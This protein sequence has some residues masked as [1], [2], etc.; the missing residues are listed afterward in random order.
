MCD[1]WCGVWFADTA[2]R[3]ERQFRSRALAD[4]ILGRGHS[5]RIVSL[6]RLSPNHRSDRGARA[7]LPLAVRVSRGLPRR[8]RNTQ[9]FSPG[10]DA[11]VGNPPWEMLRGDRGDAQTRDAARTSARRADGLRARIRALYRC[12]AT[13]TPTFINCSSSDRW[14]RLRRGG[15][16]GIVLPSGLATDHGRG[17]LAPCA[18]RPDCDRQ[19]RVVR[20]SRAVCSRS[21]AASEFLLLSATRGRPHGQQ[22]RAVSACAAAEAFDRLPELGPDRTRSHCRGPLLEQTDWQRDRYPE[23]AKSPATSTMLRAVI[24]FHSRAWRWQ[25]LARPFRSR[26]QR[27]R[28]PPPLHQWPAWPAHHRR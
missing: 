22:S 10:F 27:D 14:R 3:S 9:S 23:R 7:L 13:V 4:Q 28:R 24:V 11:I 12:R 25:R 20:K 6:R 5:S 16:L 21:I 1:L 26:A 15:R 18:P 2:R 17:D 19:P 8:P